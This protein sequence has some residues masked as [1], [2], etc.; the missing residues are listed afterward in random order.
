MEVRT[1]KVFEATVRAWNDT[2]RY[3]SSCGGTRSGK[4]F[5][6]LQLLYML[7]CFD[8]RQT[9][10]SVVSETVPHLKRGAIRDFQTM[11]GDAW[12]DDAWNKSDLIY[13][14]PSGAII[15]FFSA[16]QPGKVHGP[17]RDRLFINEVQNV[18]YD[19][20]RQLF[21]RTRGRILLDYN[22]THSFWVNEVIEPRDNCRTVHSTYLDNVD[23]ATGRSFLTDMQV[24]EIESN[25]QDAHW[26][27]VYGEGKVGTLDGLIFP[28]FEQVDDMPDGDLVECYGMDYGYT[29]DPSVLVHVRVDTRR[30]VL[31]LDEVFYER[32]LLT[33]PVPGQPGRPSIVQRMEEAGVPKRSVPIYADCAEPKTN[34]ALRAYGWNIRDSYKGRRKAEQLQ[35]MRG[36]QMKVTKRS[37]NVIRELRG[38]VWQKDRDGNALNEPAAVNDHAMDA[39][40]YAVFTHIAANDGRNRYQLLFV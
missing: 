3:V 38:Y 39:M 11:L 18:S 17:A 6:N 12:D 24:A 30:K 8:S 36:W 35:M 28:D 31:W 34:D 33:A 25:R 15:E 14:L 4:T 19:V 2:E 16:D 37:V 26:W 22:P 5:A 10:T 40:R 7:A 23:A 13:T 27:R 20:A 32:G 21:V 9:I 1:S 29:A